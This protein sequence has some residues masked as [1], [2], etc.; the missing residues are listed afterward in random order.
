MKFGTINSII[1]C[2]MKIIHI[3]RNTILFR[4]KCIVC[5]CRGSHFNHFSKSFC[6]FYCF[7][8]PCTGIKIGSFLFEE[9]IGNH[10]EFHAC[11]TSQEQHRITFW[12]IQQL[13]KQC[14]CFV[15]HRLEVFSA[16]TDFHQ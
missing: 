15:Y 5:I 6:F 11:S 7:L 8:S 9:I 13:F 16:V 10:T 1:G 12:N 14:H 2:D 3:C 4:Y